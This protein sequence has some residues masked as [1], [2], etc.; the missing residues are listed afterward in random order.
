M[1]HSTLNT[2]VGFAAPSHTVVSALPTYT[3]RVLTQIAVLF[4]VA[5]NECNVTTIMSVPVA[6]VDTAVSYRAI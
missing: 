2:E 4:F 1:S 6:G 3:V 5:L